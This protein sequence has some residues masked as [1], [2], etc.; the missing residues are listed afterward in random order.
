MVIAEVRFDMLD[1]Y[2]IKLIAGQG[3]WQ[4]DRSVSGKSVRYSDSFPWQ[5]QMD[6]FILPDDLS[7]MAHILTNGFEKIFA[8]VHEF[9]VVVMHD[10]PLEHRKLRQMSVASFVGAKAFAELEYSGITGGQK[11]FHANLGGGLQKPV[12]RWKGFNVLF[13][14]G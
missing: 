14:G 1:Q 7:G 10:V 8:L 4:A 5:R 12:S 6:G 11:S 9:P 13:R 2:L 3:V